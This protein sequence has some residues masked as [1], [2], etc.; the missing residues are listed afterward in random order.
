MREDAMAEI[1][2]ENLAAKRPVSPH[3]SI[4]RPMLTMAMSIAHRVTGAG[5]YLGALLLTLF[6]LG[7]ALG[8]GAFGAVSW[9]V[10]SVLGRVIV[11]LFSWALFHHLLGGIRH[12][13]WD[14]GLFMDPK[15]REL[16][17][18]ATLF[19]G[20]GLTVLFWIVVAIFG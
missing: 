10:N 19:G 5:L 8:P 4:Y 20:V 6:F 3:L 11:F 12:A 15:G 18:Q 7:T 13:L 9:I 14:R 16:A 1:S 2:Q 17:A